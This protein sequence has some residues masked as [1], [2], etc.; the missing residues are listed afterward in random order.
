[1]INWCPFQS[2]IAAA[3]WWLPP[4]KWTHIPNL[5]NS[6]LGLPCSYHRNLNRLFLFFA[7][8]TWW[9]MGS[10]WT[11]CAVCS[12]LNLVNTPTNWIVKFGPVISC[13]LWNVFINSSLQS[14]TTLTFPGLARYATPWCS[15]YHIFKTCPFSAFLGWPFSNMLY[16]NPLYI[17]WNDLSLMNHLFKQFNLLVIVISSNSLTY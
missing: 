15:I 10:M 1:M 8:L 13:L 9:K 16:M 6:I 4:N 14:K 3:L 11:I 12:S 5:S 2:V 7:I 17:S